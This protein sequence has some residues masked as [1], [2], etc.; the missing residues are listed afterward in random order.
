MTIYPTVKLQSLPRM[1]DFAKWG[2]AIGEALGVGLGQVFI[3]E[4][5]ANRIQQNEEII[6]NDPVLTL[7]VE[8]MRGRNEWYGLHSEL[9]KKLE[10]IAEDFTIN[11]RD[12]YFPKDATRLS[13]KLRGNKSNLE[14]AGI[15]YIPP[16]A[17]TRKNDGRY[18]S[19][20]RI[21]TASPELQ[22]HETAERV[23]L[24]SDTGNDA[25]ILKTAYQIYKQVGTSL[26][27]VIKHFRDIDIPLGKQYK[28]G[29]F[30]NMDRSHLS[31]LLQ[32]PLYVKA[33]KEIY[34]YLVSK[35][36]EI[37]DDVEAF[38]GIHGL[39]R[40][41]RS[42]GTEYIKVG[43]HEGI[44]DSETWLTVQDK[45]SH[46]QKIPNNGGGKTSWL[47][48]LAKC[49]ECG[50]ALI[51]QCSWNRAKTIAWRYFIDS[52]HYRS[53]ACSRGK[54]RA[55]IKP[56]QVEEAVLIAM[57]ERINSL[58]IA[59][60][61][62]DAPCLETEGIKAEIIRVEAEIRELMDKL[63]KADEVLFAYIQDRIKLLHS[64]KSEFEEKL[65][66][67]ARKHKEIDTSPL[68]D[69]MSRWETLT[70][71]E[72]YA[73]ASIMIDVVYVSDNDGVEIVFSI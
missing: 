51:V 42:D 8:F 33:D 5:S 34:Q 12:K 67:K 62:K 21:N 36:F 52:G 40:H 13:M 4:Y 65:R 60:T 47:V 18:L 44:I 24:D 25:E 54:S 56:D 53:S 10:E 6:N 71:E 19:L 45:K 23:A 30:T 50:Y 14:N 61:Q 41:K 17:D 16:N 1:A 72:R 70:I 46:N 66:T 11:T 43:Y 35:G 29:T 58:V 28:D 63:A 20:K 64:K 32:S 15:A 27:D 68:V 55:S 3:D 7:V 39:F 31:R 69:P 38:D 9:Y 22:R 59:E 57:Q 49:K 73:L 26:A 48:G 2:Y 37:L